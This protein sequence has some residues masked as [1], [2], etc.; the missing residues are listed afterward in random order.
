MLVKSNTER[1]LDYFVDK[2]FTVVW[3]I[4]LLLFFSA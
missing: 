4:L 1:V 3:S 2:L